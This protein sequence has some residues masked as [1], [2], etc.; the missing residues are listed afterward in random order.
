MD[1]Y[2]SA[3]EYLG[4]AGKCYLVTGAS[5]GIGRECALLLDSLGA[6]VILNGRN[7]ERLSETRSAMSGEGH[8]SAVADLS[9]LEIRPWLNEQV[10][11]AGLPLAGLAH[12]AGAHA[13]AP[14][15]AFSADKLRVALD[16]YTVMSASL[17]HAAC[18][19]KQREAQCSLVTMTSVS[20]RVAVPGNALYGAVR[21]AMESLCRSFAVEYAPMGIR[22][23]AVCGGYMEG[24]GMS[25]AGARLMGEEAKNRMASFY[26]LGLGHVREAAKAM[27]FLLGACS[28]WMTG[29][30]V[31]VDGGLSVRGV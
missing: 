5:S 15:R 14:L 21:A 10:D 18:C 25:G 4:V 26:P 30:I 6:T 16:N 17:F 7:E 8:V 3:A 19:L 20:G 31:P 24:S 2:K 23:N 29:A 22:C 27:V 9:S 11:K 1:S 12:C 13:F 28:S